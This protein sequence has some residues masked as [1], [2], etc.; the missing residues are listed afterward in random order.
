[1][2]GENERAEEEVAVAYYKI[3]SLSGGILKKLL[4]AWLRVTYPSER[5]PNTCHKHYSS[6]QTLRRTATHASV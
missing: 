1:V 3:L 4:K 6:N 2:L 5:L